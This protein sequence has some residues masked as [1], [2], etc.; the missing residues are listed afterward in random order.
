MDVTDYNPFINKSVKIIDTNI[1]EE[2]EK[3]KKKLVND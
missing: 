2:K 1:K 3:P